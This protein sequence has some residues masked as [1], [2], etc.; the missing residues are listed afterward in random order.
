[1]RAQSRVRGTAGEF[2]KKYRKENVGAYEQGAYR[3]ESASLY[4]RTE[5]HCPIVRMLIYKA[6]YRLIEW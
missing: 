1:M 6:H 3:P 2:L 4:A 5:I